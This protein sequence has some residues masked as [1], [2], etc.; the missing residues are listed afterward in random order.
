[1]LSAPQGV[2]NGKS[3]K[4][5]VS[6]VDSHILKLICRLVSPFCVDGHILCS[7]HVIAHAHTYVEVEVTSPSLHLNHMS[8]HHDSDLSTDVIEEVNHIGSGGGRAREH[9]ELGPGGGGGGGGG[10]GVRRRRRRRWWWR[11]RRRM[12]SR[13]WWRRRRRKRRRRRW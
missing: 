2:K 4:F 10:G 3:T 1:M 5:A 9:Q 8:T 13:R 12:R 11:R 7:M 6:A